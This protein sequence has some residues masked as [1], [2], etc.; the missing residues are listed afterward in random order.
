MPHLFSPWLAAPVGA[1]L[2]AFNVQAGPVL[3]R[4]HST[5]TITIGY[6]ANSAPMSYEDKGRV[7]GYAVDVCQRIASA[8]QQQLKLPKLA[9]RYVPVTAAERIAALQEGRIDLECAG[10]TNT[11]ARREQAAFGLTYFYAGASVLVHDGEGIGGLNDLRGKTLAAVKGTTG[12]QV[13]EMRERDGR[14]G[15]KL[16]LFDNTRAAVEALEQG[17]VDAVIQDNIQLVPLARQSVKKLALA[18]Q[19]LSIEPLAPMFARNDAELA[20]GVLAAMRQIYRDGEMAALYERW[21]L[22][23]LPGRTFGLDL[24]L[25]PLLNDNFRRPSSY[26]TDWAVL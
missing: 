14:A 25:N 5:Q 1:I 26:V 24:K 4:I 3:D 18:G 11:K 9:V 7:I 13:A 17:K 6:R 22:K 12:L 2:L 16:A 15:W 23:P 19:P 8:F 21:F 10:T 20:E